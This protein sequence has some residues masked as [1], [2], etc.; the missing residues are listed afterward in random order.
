MA[1]EHQ[2]TPWIEIL[3]RLDGDKPN[4]VLIINWLDYHRRHAACPRLSAAVIAPG[5]PA[6]SMEPRVLSPVANTEFEVVLQKQFSA[7]YDW[8][9]VQE[10]HS[11]PAGL[12]IVLPL[13]GVGK[14]RARIPP[15][16]Q[17]QKYV[18][19][20]GGD[21]GISEGIATAKRTGGFFLRADVRPETTVLELRREIARHPRVA[22][23]GI[24]CVE[25]S[26]GGR[27][28]NDVETVESLDLFNRLRDLA[29]V[30]VDRT[31]G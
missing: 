24:D 20:S 5:E 18:E 29:A 26:W 8:Q 22:R 9:D 28:L 10:W 14:K 21:G 6:R 11:L 17:L 31:V 30:V 12:H 1:F 23:R 3:F 2:S 7:T 19:F 13:D 15:V 16:W 4:R 27:V 25:L